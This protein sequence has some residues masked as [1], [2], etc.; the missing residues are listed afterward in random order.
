MRLPLL[1]I[2]LLSAICFCSKSIA[3]QDSALQALANLPAKYFKEVD[4]KI[5]KYSNRISGKTEKTLTKLSR[6]ENKIKNL[7][8]KAN[9]EAANR[10][11]GPGTT[12]F[13]SLLQKLKQG[14]QIADKSK[15][16]F[17]EYQDKLTT[18]LQYLETKKAQ[19]DSQYIKPLQQVSQKAKDLQEDVATTEAV[20]KFVKERK[21]QLMD[22]SLKYIGKSKYLSK[23]NKESYYY[24]EKLR[25]YKE[26]FKDKKKAEEKAMNLLHK[27]PGFDKFLQK[28]SMLASLFGGA[29]NSQQIDL[30]GLQTREGLSSIIQGKI[31]AGGPNASEAIAQ[32]LQQAQ[33]EVDK[34]KEKVLKAGGNSSNMELPDFKPNKQKSKTFFQR[35]EYGANFQSKKGSMYFP[36]TTDVGLSIG[37][38]LNDK[39]TI[40]L[41]ASYKLSLGSWEKINISH[42]GVGLRSFIDWKLKKQFLVSGGFEMNYNSAFRKFA[43]LKNLD[44]WQQSG[45]LGISKKYKINNKLKGNLQLMYDFLY[46]AHSPVSQPIVYRIG[47]GF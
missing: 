18:S 12:T 35:L 42:E 45:L 26:L 3:Q 13:S 33:A 7:L 4:K 22:E 25:N 44:E 32:K 47:F 46:R 34:L 5:G 43:S 36:S 10:L 39:S 31:A 6:W 17:D 21:K 40:G 2:L 16:R 14:K 29:G 41:G 24:V 8:Q 27:V 23:I 20:E 11:F 1:F 37:Y 19:L 15:A 38:K 28:N 9:P 30:A